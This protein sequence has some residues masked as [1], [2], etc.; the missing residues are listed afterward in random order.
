MK[1]KL[2]MLKSNLWSRPFIFNYLILK[3]MNNTNIFGSLIAIKTGNDNL[4]MKAVYVANS[5]LN[6]EWTY[7][8]YYYDFLNHTFYINDLD[9]IWNFRK[10]AIN[11]MEHIVN[12]AYKQEMNN[13]NPIAKKIQTSKN[14]NIISIYKELKT[15]DVIL[16]KIT[17]ESVK[18]EMWEIISFKNPKWD[19]NLDNVLVN[20]GLKKSWE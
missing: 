2:N 19:Y 9:N 10:S 20:L 11:I 12:E 13:L 7:F 3:S 6:N 15:D 5:T 4:T 18:N 8:V 1:N 14:P 17:L 16:D